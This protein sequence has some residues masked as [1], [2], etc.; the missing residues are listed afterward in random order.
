[1]VSFLPTFVKEVVLVFLVDLAV[2]VPLLRGEVF[3]QLLDHLL[4]GQLTLTTSLNILEKM[5]VATMSE[6]VS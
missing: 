4:Q 1:M 6:H 5:F 3:L 2:V